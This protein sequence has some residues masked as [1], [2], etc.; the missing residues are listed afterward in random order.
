[1][2]TGCHKAR[3]VTLMITITLSHYYNPK[4]T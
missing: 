1:M 3:K 4:I 2:I